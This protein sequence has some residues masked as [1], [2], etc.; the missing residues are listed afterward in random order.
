MIFPLW[1]FAL[2]WIAAWAACWFGLARIVRPIAVGDAWDAHE[3]RFTRWADG[4]E[5]Y[6]Y[7]AEAR[8]PRPVRV[9]P[10]HWRARAPYLATLR[11]F[12]AD[13]LATVL[14]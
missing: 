8:K 9:W 4:A 6:A 13:A 14:A 7:E 3:T 11:A 10:N 5:V 1:L 12:A 2:V